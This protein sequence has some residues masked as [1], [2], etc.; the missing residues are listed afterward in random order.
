MA[1]RNDP[2]SR[3][4]Y[5]AICAQKVRWAVGVAALNAWSFA[6]FAV[7]SA[8]LLVISTLLGDFTLAALGI[9]AVL[10]V[11]AYF[12]FRGKQMLKELDPAGC[13]VLGWNQLGL[14]AALVAYCGWSIVWGV[15]YPPSEELRANPSWQLLES[16][17][18]DALWPALI[19]SIY[20]AIIVASLIYQ[21]W[22]A[23]YY[24]SRKRFVEE[25]QA[26]AEQKT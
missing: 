24:F 16:E 10:G 8:V 11:V 13:L 9:T 23:W 19:A 12:E 21:G 20:G 22:N 14:L 26:M 15:L 3:L 25:C 5:H 18:G 2:L 6:I 4:P 1:P 7:A 17:F